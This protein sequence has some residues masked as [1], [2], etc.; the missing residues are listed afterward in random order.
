VFFICH[1]PSSFPLFK[2]AIVRAQNGIAKS[3]TIRFYQLQHNPLS[4][5]FN[6]NLLNFSTAIK[7]IVVMTAPLLQSIIPDY[8]LTTRRGVA[9]ISFNYL[10]NSAS[11][12]DKIQ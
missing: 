4:S 8:L 11:D 12:T 10:E 5:L 1:S 2:I 3:S 7:Q 6:V 9:A